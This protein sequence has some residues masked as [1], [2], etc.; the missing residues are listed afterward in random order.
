MDRATGSD[1]SASHRRG[2]PLGSR[3]VAAA[4]HRNAD[5]EVAHGRA[6]DQENE[7]HGHG[8]V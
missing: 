7:V 2:V 1:D 4:S 6:T 8:A 5:L 3:T